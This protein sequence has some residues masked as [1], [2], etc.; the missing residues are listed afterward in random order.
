MSWMV[1]VGC[2][3]TVTLTIL[4]L[5]TISRICTGPYTVSATLPVIAVSPAV[6]PPT[7]LPVGNSPGTVVEDDED[8]VDDPPVPLVAATGVVGSCDLKDSRATRPA[9]VPV[10][11]RT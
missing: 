3:S 7:A 10:T 6:R 2:S 9:M 1:L 4:W 8:D 5:F 11:A